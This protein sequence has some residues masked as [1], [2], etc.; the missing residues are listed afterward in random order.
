MVGKLQNLPIKSLKQSEFPNDFQPTNAPNSTQR[1]SIGICI[2]RT[3]DSPADGLIITAQLHKPEGRVLVFGS[4]RMMI[5]T[6][7]SVSACK[8]SLQCD[9][10]PG[11]TNL[12]KV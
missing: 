6:Q 1:M 3:M 7:L 11:H 10:N 4:G 9:L 2:D 12:T 8:V 5:N